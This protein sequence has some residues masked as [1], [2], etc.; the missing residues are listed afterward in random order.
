MTTAPTRPEPVLVDVRE[1]ARLTGRSPETVRRW[2]WAGRLV[3]SRQ[4]HRLLVSRLEVVALGAA[5]AGALSLADW[6]A[7]ARKSLTGFE[8]G[9]R[10]SAADLVLRDRASRAGAGQSP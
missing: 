2:V 9:A 7:Q 10:G 3:A 6:A 5:G 1:A 8:P 4:G